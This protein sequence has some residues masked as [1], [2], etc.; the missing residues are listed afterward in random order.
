MFRLLLRNRS[1]V[2]IRIRGG[3][4]LP[5][6]NHT[7]SGP[8]QSGFRVRTKDRIKVRCIKHGVKPPVELFE[9]GAGNV[10]PGLIGR[11]AETTLKLPGE[12]V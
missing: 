5:L 4:T 6:E 1:G 8:H 12:R 11:K 3:M 9:V 7:R 10:C 2:S